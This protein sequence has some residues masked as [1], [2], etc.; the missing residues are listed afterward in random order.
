LRLFLY[1]TLQPAADTAMARWLRPRIREAQPAS[2][3]GRLFAIPARQG[4]YPALL[5]GRE[6]CRGALVCVDLTRGDLARVARYEGGEY[7]RLALRVRT[8]GGLMQCSGFV[9]RGAALRDAV[10]IPGGD[11]LLWLEA[12]RHVAYGAK[13]EID[14]RARACHRAPP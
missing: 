8:S 9:W 4:W 2:V 12:T 3:P 6:R 14:P 7:R 1:G 13:A 11:F 5:P 10:P